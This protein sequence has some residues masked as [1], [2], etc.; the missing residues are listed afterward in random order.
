M[1]QLSTSAKS[2]LNY[3]FMAW[4]AGKVTHWGLKKAFKTASEIKRE[5]PPQ[6]IANQVRNGVRKT[7]QQ[8]VWAILMESQK[9]LE[10][11]FGG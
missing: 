2:A 11:V 10:T 7:V 8:A 5:H 6:K 4:D 9:V 1:C 3:G